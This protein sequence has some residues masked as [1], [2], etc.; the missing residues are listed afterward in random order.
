ME[1]LR[2][3]S[4]EHWAKLP[5]KD[6]RARFFVE[7]YIEKLRMH[8]PHF[9]QA[10]LMNI[11]S[12]CE[13]TIEYVKAYR[14]ND[15]FSGYVVSSVEE[16]EDCWDSDSIAQ[17]ILSDL[18]PLRT[19]LFKSVRAADLSTHTLHRLTALCRAIISRAKTY[20][21]ALSEALQDAITGET[22]ITQ[23]DRI[24]NQI[25][26]LAG[27]YVTSL[28]NQ[29]F[30]PTYLFNRAEMFTRE[31]SYSDR[32]FDQ[33]LALVIGR[34]KD[35]K[36][37]DF[38]VY[39]GIKA[40]RASMLLSIG[41]EPE[42]GFQPTLTEDLQPL[43]AQAFT[44]G[45]RPN[46]I[47]KCTISAT[48]HI[49]A[50]LKAKENL[51]K[52]LDIATALEMSPRLQISK[53]CIVVQRQ[54]GAHKRVVDVDTLLAFMSSEVGAHFSHV[55]P[56][57]RQSF[58][59]FNEEAKDQMGR[60]LRH[61]RLA[62]TSVSFEQKLLNLWIALES[63]FAYNES[64][65]LSNILEYVPQFYAITGLARRVGY[66]RALLISNKI[67]TTPA[68]RERI[69]DGSDVFDNSVTDRHIFLLIRDEISAKEL[70]ES[71]KNKE[72]L[73]FRIFQIFRELKDNSSILSRIN[74]TKDDV[75]RQLRRIYFM[76]NKIA[77]TGHFQGVRPQ[78][79]THL[80]D[81]I[82]V[83]YRAI[84]SA[85]SESNG[86]LYS[87]AELL[88]AARMGADIV[89]DRASGNKSIN[90]LEDILSSPII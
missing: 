68:F 8:T 38:E 84:A 74:R 69:F 13:E 16:I 63:L 40:S 70:F 24:T 33:Q 58:V 80:L 43:R 78:L 77:H 81:Y 12:A 27:L 87:V 75:K 34:L 42:I 65:I 28:L 14:I 48:D 73:K 2:Y 3:L 31:N 39:Y 44:E 79:V 37:L 67:D 86:T 55:A 82:A 83:S 10:R 9:Y 20:R 1:K 57:I 85:A 26:R 64:T 21:V 66:L 71:L 62:R 90:T 4:D 5:V 72:H 36:L 25:D 29:K 88:A 54:G 32:N 61:L 46:V 51:D 11:L 59:S 19:A 15:K 6:F 22:E 35:E 47:A 45:M 53:G 49:N 52:F 23:K 76:R 60:S 89:N 30:S 56:S 50:A 41:D 17:E 18:T 7:S